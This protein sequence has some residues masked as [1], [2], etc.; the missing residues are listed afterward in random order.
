MW[1]AEYKKRFLKELARLPPHIR[2]KAEE[3]VFKEMP[4]V[5]PFR[6]GYV[7]KMTGYANK[8]KIRVGSYRIGLTIDTGASLVTFERVADRK[9]IYRVFP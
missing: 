9:D 1:R 8:H 3:I 7:E 2:E 4:G 5:D 6:V